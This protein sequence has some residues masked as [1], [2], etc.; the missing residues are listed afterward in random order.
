M[1]K[2][3]KLLKA[4]RL[5]AGR[6]SVLGRVLDHRDVYRSDIIKTYGLPH[7]LPQ[8][9]VLDL[10]PNLDESVS[11]YSFLRT[12]SPPLDLA[13][14]KGL[15]KRFVDCNY[16]EIGTWRG[17]SAANL[18]SVARHCTTIDMSDEELR[19]RHVPER[20]IDIQ[21][22]YS[23]ALPNVK[24]IQESSLTFDFRSLH[25][26]YDLIFVDGDHR[27]EGVRRDTAN[28]F[29]LLRDESSIIVW[30]DYGD[31]PEDVR[32]EVLKAI[33]DGTPAAK[34]SHLY[35]VSNT[36]CA[37]YTTERIASAYVEYPQ[38]P[39]KHFEVSIRARKA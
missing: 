22:F 34:R 14:L 7:G 4:L 39:D 11:P 35:R 32:W 30:H 31:T 26:R 21:R 16:L 8:V 20:V 23:K 3:G 10:V 19:S 13:L 27:Y 17:E 12:T 33:L 36:M 15:A 25:E 1:G 5:I 28:A 24:H 2:L 29:T 18:A 37:I 9:D 38:R 6:P